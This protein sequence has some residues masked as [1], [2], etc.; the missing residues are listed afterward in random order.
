MEIVLDLI[1]N[2]IFYAAIIVLLALFKFFSHKKKRYIDYYE[3]FY[4]KKNDNG[5]FF[6]SNTYNFISEIE[7]KFENL[8]NSNEIEDYKIEYD[9]ADVNDFQIKNFPRCY[10]WFQNH[11]IWFPL[12]QKGYKSNENIDE[13]QNTPNFS[14]NIQITLTYNIERDL[15]QDETI[16]SLINDDFEYYILNKNKSDSASLN[17][18]INI[19]LQNS[20]FLVNHEFNESSKKD[21][22][23]FIEKIKTNIYS[24]MLFYSQATELY[25]WFHV[26][27]KNDNDV[28]LIIHS[29]KLFSSDDYIVQADIIIKKDLLIKELNNLVEEINIRLNYAERMISASM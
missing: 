7:E 26:W 19:K 10:E 21:I 3:V 28:R 11:W 5:Y 23:C 24:N 22:K 6:E 14:N 15:E 17:L 18:D 29:Y 12:Y 25:S 9:Y 4:K 8:K 16:E 20:S 1:D 2:S 13:P 27:Q